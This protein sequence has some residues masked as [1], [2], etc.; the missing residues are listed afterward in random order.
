MKD[1]G[2][3]QENAIPAN[4]DSTKVA[5]TGFVKAALDVRIQQF[6]GITWDESADT[7]TRTGATAGT[8]FG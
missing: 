4:D 7:Y 1:Y 3:T 5:T 2:R 8:G 6:Y